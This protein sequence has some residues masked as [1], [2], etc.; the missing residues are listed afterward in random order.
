MEELVTTVYLIGGVALAIGFAAMCAE[1]VLAL[2]PPMG[3]DKTQ[4]DP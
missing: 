4:T 1:G 2:L 3:D